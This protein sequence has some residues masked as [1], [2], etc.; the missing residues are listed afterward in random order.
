V[1]KTKPPCAP[2]W[3]Y[4]ARPNRPRGQRGRRATPIT[5]PPRAVISVDGLLQKHPNVPDLVTVE[6]PSFSRWPRWSARRRD[7]TTLSTPVL[8]RLVAR[9]SSP[10]IRGNRATTGVLL[11][12]QLSPLAAAPH[13]ELRR[14]S[15]QVG[16]ATSRPWTRN[17]SVV[18]SG[19]GLAG[20]GQHPEPDHP[21][22][23]T[24]I[25]PHAAG[26]PE[27]LHDR[28]PSPVPQGDHRL[29]GGAPAGLGT[30]WV[31]TGTA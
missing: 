6:P 1:S 14:A 31:R 25:D 16:D 9:H 12:R 4:D 30:A 3:S 24:L 15:S 22:H 19:H 28:L 7:Y 8:V 23:R 11:R 26:R 2:Q 17:H 21:L 18:E 10:V 29:R 27:D 13:H 5:C 20:A